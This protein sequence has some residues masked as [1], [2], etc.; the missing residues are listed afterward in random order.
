MRGSTPALGIAGIQL[1]LVLRV[2]ARA[3]TAST[4]GARMGAGVCSRNE[5]GGCSRDEVGG[6][7]RNEVG[8]CSRNEVG[9][10]SRNEVGGCSRNEVGVATASGA[11]NL[12]G[13][14]YIISQ[15]E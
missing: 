6:C 11:Y 9:G 4:Q 12:P 15:M 1:N 14:L 13:L 2:Q 8:G 10:C 5:V 3:H 7:S